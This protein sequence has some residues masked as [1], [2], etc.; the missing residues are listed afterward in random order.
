M[1]FYNIS[2]LAA[3]IFSTSAM[4]CKCLHT[5]T[6]DPIPESTKSCCEIAGG[7]YAGDDCTIDSLQNN[8]LYDFRICCAYRSALEDC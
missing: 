7:N 2:V 5:S 6:K 8:N 4:A 3:A 1:Q